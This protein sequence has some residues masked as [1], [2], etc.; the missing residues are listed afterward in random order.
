MKEYLFGADVGGTT[1]KLGVFRT[2]GTLL[3]KWEI[4]TRTENS[5]ESIIPDIADACR[6]YLAEHNLSRE[7]F[8]GIGMG[9]PGPVKDDGTVQVC[10]NLGWGYRDVKSEMEKA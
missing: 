10:V 8:A 9:I 6:N 1:V 3:D 5:G 4:P 2:D 7:D